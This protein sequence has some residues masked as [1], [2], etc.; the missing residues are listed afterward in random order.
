M[1]GQIVA[2]FYDILLLITEVSLNELLL[3][4]YFSAIS[5]VYSIS[6]IVYLYIIVFS[7]SFG[8]LSAPSYNGQFIQ[9]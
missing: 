6:T 3:I 2:I 5:L 7:F 4:L 8:D 9:D 1:F